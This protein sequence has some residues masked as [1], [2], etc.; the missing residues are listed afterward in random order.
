MACCEGDLEQGDLP[1]QLPAWLQGVDAEK[2][3]TPQWL[4][5]LFYD[6]PAREPYLAPARPA[7]LLASYIAKRQGM[8][9]PF[10]H[11]IPMVKTLLWPEGC[12]FVINSCGKE[13][14]N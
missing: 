7:V 4:T 6:Q 3:P 1:M 2:A 13:G 14:E 8:E 5:L 12:C 11:F 10:F 9:E